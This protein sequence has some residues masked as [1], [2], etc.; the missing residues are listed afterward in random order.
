MSK[1]A[2]PWL[3]VLLLAAVLGFGWMQAHSSVRKSVDFSQQAFT[4]SDSC[5]EC[6]EERHAS[7]HDTYHRS[8]TQ[9]ANAQTVR[10]DFNGE[11]HTYWGYTI[12]PVQE[13]GR[14]YFDYYQPGSEALL[15][16]LEITRTVGSRRYQQYLAQTNET[17]GNFYRLEMLWHIEDARWVHLNGAFL[18]S[19]AQSFDSHT[20]IWN[21]NCIFCH[22]TGI[23]PGMNNYDEI[24]DKARRGEPYDLQKDSMFDSHVAELGIACESCHAA[25][26]YHLQVSDQLF[27]KY[28]MHFTDSADNSIVNP[29][30]LSQQRSLDVCGQCHG[31][32]TPKTL[33]LARTWMEDGPTYR[34]GDLL[35]MHVN[36][37]LRES[38]L[39]TQKTD[40]FASRFW[41]D[42]TPRL[43]AYEYQGILMSACRQD[44]RLTCMSCHDMHGGDVN[45]MLEPTMRSNAGCVE[46]HAALVAD[47][48]PHTGHAAD[49]SGSL[50]YDCHMPKMTYGIMTFHRNHKIE[51]PD[52]V[53]EFAIDKPNACVNCHVD[54]SAEWVVQASAELWPG[55]VEVT[56]G[57]STAVQSLQSLHSGDPV[58]RGIAAYH[59]GLDDA[60]LPLGRRQFLIPH[61]L[62]AMSD[63]YPGIRRFAHRSLT[64]IVDHL[65]TN[66]ASLRGFQAALLPF[67]FIA[68]AEAREQVLSVAQ[69]RLDALD[70]SNWPAPPTGA[71]MG[72][73]YRLQRETLERLRAEA[74]ASNKA[75]DIGE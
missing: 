34:P 38:Q 35:Q 23:T 67:D 39:P 22:N 63:D 2:L 18:G 51:S 36:P 16:R 13:E 40:L 55:S 44:E 70:V 20:A 49:S 43:T 48:T 47:P 24:V 11:A 8:M 54:R 68:D 26:E 41:A 1:K 75:I 10:G 12:R 28:Y 33:A 9:A 4:G 3:A 32:R 15:Q 5:R 74:H 46:C 66:D 29:S 37:V 21:Q 50:C 31:Q 71:L 58:E 19:D 14:Y 65:A 27:R 64:A 73:D 25:G 62:Y 72:A 53:L 57:Y 69:A 30:R 17:D 61:L 42:G 45:G 56:E 7:W 6:H 52:P 60:A 59:M